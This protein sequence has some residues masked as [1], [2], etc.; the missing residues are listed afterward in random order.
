MVNWKLRTFPLKEILFIIHNVE[1]AKDEVE[2]EAEVEAKV[3]VEEE[4]EVEEEEESKRRKD[5]C[6]SL[7][8]F[9]R[10]RR[11]RRNYFASNISSNSDW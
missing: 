7:R 3:E 5:L 4:A 10:A 8:C 2:E 11:W 1:E 9:Q 6:L